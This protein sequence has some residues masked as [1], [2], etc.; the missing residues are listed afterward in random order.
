MY[1]DEAKGEV[2][3]MAVFAAGKYKG[4]VIDCLSKSRLYPFHECIFATW[5]IQII[6]EI[7]SEFIIE[8]KFVY[9]KVCNDSDQ[10][11]QQYFQ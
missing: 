3:D 1:G 9:D 8:F 11:I 7:R 2:A 6:A 10:S 4:A 5:K